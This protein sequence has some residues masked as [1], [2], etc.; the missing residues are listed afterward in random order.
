MS[1]TP[2]PAH[3]W[4]DARAPGFSFETLNTPPIGRARRGR[5]TTPH[6]VVD[7]PAFIFCGTKAAIKAASAEMMAQ[8]KTQIILSN[9]YH[10]MLQPGS[11]IVAAAGGLHKF[12]GWD[13]PMLTDSGG[14]QIFSLAHGGVA[15]EIKSARGRQPHANKSLLKITE[16]GAAFR[17]HIDGS[18]HLL[19]PER[20]VQ[21]QRELG[22][23]IILTLDEC[24]PFHVDRKYTAR[25]LAMTQ[26]WEDRSMH[27]FSEPFGAYAP[28][29]G[30][31][32]AQALYGISQ[33]GVYP[34]LRQESAAY[35]LSR[36]F[37]GHAVGGSLGADKSQMY[38]VVAAAMD[39]LVSSKPVHLLG[40]GG[41]GDIFACVP[42]G[43]DTF[44]CV[45]PTRM[46]RHGWALVPGS[47][48]ESK[49]KPGHD[50]RLNLRNAAHKT[51]LRPL[52][53]D[54]ACQACL[55][56]SR[57]YLHHLFKADEM[58][59]QMLLT[60]HNVATVNRVMGDVRAGLEAGSLNAARAYWMGG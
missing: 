12:M 20:S 6:G 44:D 8:S 25:S 11:A 60:A 33:G 17:S 36:P 45:S 2:P 51:D 43:I 1:V 59:G 5:L 24:T 9:T 21:I 52:D 47:K 48:L 49:P 34:D 57:S 7:T 32:G 23:D 54:C 56:Y 42:L 30:S 46:A 31:A 40:I 58:V 27:A 26:R 16:K 38:D 55:K 37:F 19:T 3:V 50:P 13:G 10:L 53:E 14:F 35:L 28:Y 41:I 18:H 15:D 29:H 4:T 22:A 39:T